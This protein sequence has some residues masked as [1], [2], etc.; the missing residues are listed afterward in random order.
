MAKTIFTHV[1]ITCNDPIVIEKFYAKHFGFK[2]ARVYEPGP[3]QVVMIK[4]GDVYLELFK[5]TEE[6]PFSQHKGSGPEFPSLRHLA[7]LVDD[8]DAK[9]REMGG[10][11]QISL[12]P[13]EMSQYIPGMKACWIKD[14]EGNIIE[15]NQ[16]YVDE[17]KP[18]PLYE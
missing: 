15:L 13:L 5:A 17:N 12:G 6:A 3:N 14:P 7:F 16:G 8:L 11:A 18:P 9:L 10:D 2:R 4:S 1:G